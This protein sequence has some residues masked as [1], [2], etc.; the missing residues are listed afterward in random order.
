MSMFARTGTYKYAVVDDQML[1]SN[2]A[3][4]DVFLCIQVEQVG[5]RVRSV[6][7]AKQANTPR[8]KWLN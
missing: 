1:K 2:G 4:Y 5:M 8:S 7:S 6:C 3:F